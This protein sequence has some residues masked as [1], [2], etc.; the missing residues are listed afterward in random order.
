MNIVS[1]CAFTCFKFNISAC[2]AFVHQ[3]WRITLHGP[4]SQTLS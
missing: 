4:N 1:V 2:C 3:N